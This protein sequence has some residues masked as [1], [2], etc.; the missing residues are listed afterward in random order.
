MSEIPSPAELHKWL[1]EQP[2]GY[3]DDITRISSEGD[4]PLFE[5]VSGDVLVWIEANE[6]G[7]PKIKLYASAPIA[8]K[9]DSSTNLGFE[10]VLRQTLATVPG[11]AQIID[12]DDP[13]AVWDS[14][15][16]LFHRPIYEGGLSKHSVISALLTLADAARQ[17]MWLAVSKGMLTG[18]HSIGRSSS[19]DR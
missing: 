3:F 13:M 7:S 12:K 17:T 15:S 1:Q 10:K 2:V 8:Q 16:V 4:K 14:A 5:L 11:I 9:Y 19:V 6:T 18:H